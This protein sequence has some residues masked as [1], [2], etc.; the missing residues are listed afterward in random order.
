VRIF[1]SAIVAASWL[2]WSIPAH[3]DEEPWRAARAHY[4]R[5]VELAN[6]GEYKTALEEFKAAYAASPHFAVLYNIGQA[7]VA[8]GRPRKAIDTLTKYLRDGKDDVPAPR[9][10]QVEA[11]I[12]QLESIFATLSITTDPS[13]AE[14]TV[15]GAVL[16]RSPLTVL[17][18][19]AGSHVVTASRADGRPATRV[20]SLVEGE[21]LPLNLTLPQGEPRVLSM[22]CWELG[23]Q[24][25]LN[26]QPID[27]AKAG[28][29]VPVEAGRLRVGFSSPDRQWPEQFVEVPP[30]VRATVLCGTAPEAQKAPAAG[31]ARG[32]PTGYVLVGAGVVMGG[33]ALAQGLWNAGRAR[34]WEIE[35]ASIDADHSSGHYERQV[36]NNELAESID[37]GSTVTVVL[38]ASAGALVAGGVVWLLTDHSPSGGKSTKR[39][40]LSVPVRFEVARD[41]AALTWQGAF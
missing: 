11:Q 32:F 28:L 37:R 20:V 13:G 7:E 27:P 18:L 29:G 22:Q 19:A 33:V 39:A 24:P 1:A 16:G 36:A 26:G 15:D 25:M 14:V 6:K 3:A 9:R 5:G 21:Q 12:A 23:A 17:H 4:E 40:S 41:S 2:A 30:G 34:D 8:L 31:E 35:Q 10:K 38:T